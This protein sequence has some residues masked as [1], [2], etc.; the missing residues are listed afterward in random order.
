MELRYIDAHCHL[1]FAEYDA[2]REGLI[3]QMADRGI[4]GIVVGC[5]RESSEKAAALVGNFGN[6]WAAVGIH[7][8]HESVEPL[9]MKRLRALAENPKVVAIGE[10]GLDY[11]RPVDTSDAAKAVQKELFQAQIALAA[12]LDKPLILHVRPSKGTMDAYTDAIEIL[13]E[14][15]QKFP[16]LRGD[17]HFF[18]GGIEELHALNALDFTVSFTAVVTFARNYDAVIKAAPL[19]MML[20]ETDAPYVA[21]VSRRGT[22]NDSLAVEEIVASIAEVRGEAVE[23][24]RAALLANAERLFGLGRG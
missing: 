13:K 23:S 15:K 12:E 7:P 22:R 19:D 21:P 3:A 20:V 2:D 8:N 16:N 6:L 1:Q 9:D 4:G 18:V 10:C 17:V 14:E 24:V 11:F 5:D